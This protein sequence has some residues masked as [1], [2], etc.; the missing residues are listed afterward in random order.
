LSILLFVVMAI[1]VLAILYIGVD[2]WFRDPDVNLRFDF[3]KLRKLPLKFGKGFMWGSA[4]A[5][6]QIEGGCTN[7]NWSQ[8]ESA[9]DTEGKPKILRGQKA[10]SCDDSWNLYKED[11]QLMKGLSLNSYRF[12]VEWSK[13][14]PQQGIFDEAALDHYE[15]VV[16]DLLANGIE[17]MVT[18]HH[19]TNPVWFEEKGAFLQD[20]SPQTFV[21]FA[22]KVIQ[23]LSPKVK[24][25]CTINEPAIYAVLG[26]FIAE[27][28]PAVVDAKKA[29]VVY[30]NLLLAHT[31]TYQVIKKIRPEAQVGMAVHVA[32]CD[33]FN[34][35]NLVDVL[36][37]RLLN[38]NMNDSHMEYL[39]KGKFHFFLPGMVDEKYSGG[40]KDCFDYVGL[41][42][43]RNQ[44]RKFQPFGKDMFLEVTKSPKDQLTDMG[45]EIYPEGLYRSLK[46]IRR[47]TSKP[48]YITENGIADE[49]DTKRAKYIEDHLLV[50]NKAIADGFNIRG[51]YYWSLLDNFEWAHGFDGKFGLYSVDLKTKKRTMYQGSSKY[52]EIIGESNRNSA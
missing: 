26:Y 20:S 1:V 8:F 3:N 28:P 29:A 15:K 30:K 23:R 39:A 6:H 17:P 35:W 40:E 22:E 31:A 14:E 21:K 2:L 33:P 10:G 50:I 9:V 27:F 34:Q 13:I 11:T 18:L 25:W 16:D 42:Y 24:I 7:S 41:N 4:T 5:S 44:Y 19:F 49:K 37:A 36:I 52:K 51:Y 32:I 45:W 12:S 38:S 47:Y 43:Y 48:I 46:M